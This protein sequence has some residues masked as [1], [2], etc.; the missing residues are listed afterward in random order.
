MKLPLYLTAEEVDFMLQA[1]KT[2]PD[3]FKI[4]SVL[5]EMKQRFADDAER[6]RELSARCRTNQYWERDLH[7]E[8]QEKVV[9][10]HTKKRVR[11]DKVMAGIK[12]LSPAEQAE[13]LAALR[14]K[15]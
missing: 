11:R 2:R 10:A 12:A 4:T 9:V 1:L 14:G 3:P 13:L 5:K 8:A 7:E 6:L 15:V